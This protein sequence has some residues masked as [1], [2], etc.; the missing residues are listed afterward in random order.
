M[1]PACAMD[2]IPSGVD[3]YMVLSSTAVAFQAGMR[4]EL[5]VTSIQDDMV[6]AQT[7]C[8]SIP[9]ICL[10][11]DFEPWVCQYLRMGSKFTVLDFDLQHGDDNAGIKAKTGQLLPII[12]PQGEGC[13][14]AEAFAGLGGWSFGLQLGKTPVDML[15]ECDM[16]T[17]RACADSHRCLLLEISEALHFLRQGDL[18]TPFVLHANIRDPLVY[19][20]AG[21]LGVGWWAAS[22]PCQPW[23]RAAGQS[24]LDS[25]DGQAFLQF[26]FAL[27]FS[28]AFGG[29]FENV[30]G[31]PRHHH[32][33]SLKSAMK[34]CGFNL[35][36]SDVKPAMPAL[37]V[38][39]KR[40]LAIM[41]KDDVPIHDCSLRVVLNMG[42]APRGTHQQE[43]TMEGARCVQWQLQDWEILQCSP[44]QDALDLMSSYEFLPEELKMK[45]EPQNPASVILGLRIRTTQ[46]PLQP[47]M[48]RQGSQ[49]KLP[50]Q[51][52]RSK[53]LL[54]YLLKVGNNNRY[55]TPYEVATCMGFP[56]TLVLPSRYQDAW[57]MVGNALPIFHAAWHF[58]RVWYLIG[59]VLKLPSCI[60]NL[61]ELC[62]ALKVSRCQ[63]EDYDVHKVGEWME[64]HPKPFPMSMAPASPLVHV[65][66]M[67]EEDSDDEPQAKRRCISP[68]WQ[69]EPMQVEPAPLDSG[70]GRPVNEALCVRA[71]EAAALSLASCVLDPPCEHDAKPVRILHTKGTWVIGF[72]AVG[73]PKVGDLLKHT[74][75]HAQAWHFED[76][77]LNN[78]PVVFTSKARD[79]G[80]YSIVFDPMPCVRTIRASFMNR[81][82]EIEVDVT[83]K[84]CDMAGYVAAAAD[85]LPT[86]V[87]IHDMHKPLDQQ[88]FV[89]AHDLVQFDCELV[90]QLMECWR[91]GQPTTTVRIEDPVV[92]QPSMQPCQ[93]AIRFTIADPKW[94][95]IRSVS[96]SPEATV[97]QLMLKLLPSM[98]ETAMPV[99]S[100]GVVTYYGECKLKDVSKHALE[101][102][103][104]QVGLPVGPVSV[105]NHEDPLQVHDECMHLWVKGPFEHRAKV[106]K[107]PVGWTLLNIATHCVKDFSGR[108]TMVVMQGGRGV[109]PKLQVTLLD[110][111][112]TLDIRACALP[113]GA[114]QQEQVSTKLRHMLATRGVDEAALSARVSLI[115]SKI[116]AAELSSIL[117]QEEHLAWGAL[118]K[119]ANLVKLRMITTVELQDFQKKQRQVKSA[120]ASSSA[121]PAVKE[122]KPKKEKKNAGSKPDKVTIELSHFHSEGALTKLDISQ[123]GPDKSGVAIATVEEAMK[124]LP[125]TKLAVEPLALVVLTSANFAGQ[126]PVAVPAVNTAGQPTLASVVILNYG[127]MEVSCKPDVPKVTLEA[128][129]TST[130]EVFIERDLVPQWEDCQCPLTYMGQHLPEIRQQ[131]V[132][133]SWAFSPFNGSKVKCK[134]QDAQYWHG[135][136]RIPEEHLNATLARSGRLA[137]SSRSVAVTSV[138][139]ADLV[140]SQFMDS[141][142]RR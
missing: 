37:P 22:P 68:T 52:L 98:C 78:H 137:C 124:L 106:M 31:L 46:E 127:D 134:H 142:W 139:T 74:L 28:G 108:M 107:I 24:G 91:P 5:V 4:V 121:P 82:V 135:Y 57:Q 50:E 39:R 83:W 26:V 33:A 38:L 113:G 3:D 36:V 6:W 16:L 30:P 59:S 54:A 70:V 138:W 27:C 101:I 96:M 58:M 53:G 7:T 116:P 73:Q 63:L 66:T 49:H 32:Y 71:P 133:A 41:V 11:C 117:S 47:I 95:T 8:P 14:V 29:M 2:A 111:N 72:H 9:N 48:A 34:A 93:N 100:S 99:L 90:P 104:P 18:P 69:F 105:Q 23:S 80:H 94:A 19:V 125:V 35:V 88:S 84:L 97:D 118:K 92:P 123:W 1:G 89:L 75:P 45:C 131:K 136:V 110:P 86:Q 115:M 13:R 56:A 17:A 122:S 61:T 128:T 120:S 15:V 140:L 20:V 103:Y 25:Q 87:R 132:I 126:S 81:D 129:P 44:S 51:L 114:K 43:C 42:I 119:Q 141:H 79:V 62:E 40:W 77:H 65:G 85:V 10:K 112:M 76:I 60:T 64:L 55:T 67:I 102:S 130:L 109:D 12:H 21:M